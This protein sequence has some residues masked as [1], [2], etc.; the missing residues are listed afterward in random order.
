MDVQRAESLLVEQAGSV[1]SGDIVAA[2]GATEADDQQILFTEVGENGEL[3]GR[4]LLLGG[5]LLFCGRLALKIVRIH[6]I[7]HRVSGLRVRPAQYGAAQR[8]SR[9]WSSSGRDR[10]HALRRTR[11]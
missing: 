9:G 4:R 3:A 6:W 8:R 1:A 2:Q 5:L 11:G 7:P 10:R